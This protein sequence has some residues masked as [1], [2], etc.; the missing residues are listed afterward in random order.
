M[1]ELTFISDHEDQAI[2]RLVTQFRGEEY[3]EGIV[4]SLVS[5]I[6]SLED[7]FEELATER[8]VMNAVGEQLDL[9]GDLV[10]ESRNGRDDGEY[11][12]G[13]FIRIGSNVSHGTPEDLLAILILATGSDWGRIVELFPAA[14][15]LYC[16]DFGS[17]VG[18]DLYDIIYRTAP[19]AIGSTLIVTGGGEARGDLLV[20]DL[21]GEHETYGGKGLSELNTSTG[22]DYEKLGIIPEA[23][24]F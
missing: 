24:T 22:L 23:I 17:I 2:A 21:P 13:I 11:R 10:G 16:E 12:I 14:F 1:S 8:D 4:A 9:L 15:N 19:A 5:E 7:V 20:F 18:E 6:Q 3:I